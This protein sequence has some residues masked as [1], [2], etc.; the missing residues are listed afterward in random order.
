MRSKLRLAIVEVTVSERAELESLANRRKTA[1][2][3]AMR[4]RVVLGCASGIRNKD[5]ATQLGID[6]VTVSKGRRRFLA[7]A[8]AI[9]QLMS[10][11]TDSIDRSGLI[12]ETLEGELRPW[13]FA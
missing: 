10:T 6:P 2:A 5:V 4:A 1:Q 9:E 11:G 7:D 3:L 12:S 8:A 13:R